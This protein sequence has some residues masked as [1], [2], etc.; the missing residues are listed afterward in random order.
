MIRILPA[1]QIQPPDDA[2]RLFA[3]A[4]E[5]G[6]AQTIARALAEIVASID[7]ATLAQAISENRFDALWRHLAL[8]RLG[9]ALRP[10]RNRLA[11]VH[12]QTALAASVAIADAP[13]VKAGPSKLVTPA[14]IPLSYD[15]TDPATL[16]AQH[17]R[18]AALV[19][20]VETTA[21]AGAQ[22][23]LSDGLAQGK[24][25]A[26]IARTLRETLGMSAQE[27]NAIASYRTALEIGSLMPL[28]RALRDRRFDARIRRGDLT[29]AQIDQMVSRYAERYRQFRALRLAR[30]ATLSA[31]NQGRLAAW[32]QY[33]AATGRAPRRFWLTAGDELVCPIC[34][35]IP[36]MNPDGIALEA[37]YA[38]PI[39]PIAAP[40][41]PH[42]NCRCTETFAR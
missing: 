36:G 10:V 9:P 3:E 23:I 13:L 6:I 33:A 41:D 39:G 42:P 18:D 8:D 25:P 35:A 31:A 24:S 22:Q 1:S 7:L 26:Q 4:A 2:A 15:P 34:A 20:G 14:V 32:T 29:A 37:R 17:A 28:Q 16:A 40:P 5:R 19:S 12:D 30:T 38:S 11:V 27:A 21:E